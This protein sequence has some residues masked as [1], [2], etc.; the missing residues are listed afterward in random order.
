MLSEPVPGEE[1][2]VERWIGFTRRLAWDA[3]RRSGRTGIENDIMSD[4]LWGLLEA[5]RTFDP[6]GGASPQRWVAY[7]VSGRIVD[8]IRLRLGDPRTGI[9]R[10]RSRQLSL[11]AFLEGDPDGGTWP[12]PN[13]PAREAT[14]KADVATAL[15]ALT[16]KQRQVV[17]AHLLEGAYLQEVAEALGVTESAV[18]HQI[19]T[20]KTRMRR[21]LGDAA[22]PAP[23]TPLTGWWGAMT[24]FTPHPRLPCVPRCA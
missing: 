10:T 14:A 4:A 18:G 19:R 24:A 17:T 1:E 5:A 21:A 2:F 20:A 15:A 12:A 7:R 13:H 22:Q 11:D 16:P 23:H 3:V 8:G 9:G 6:E